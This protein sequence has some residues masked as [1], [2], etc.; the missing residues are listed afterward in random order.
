MLVGDARVVALDVHLYNELR[1]EMD[2]SV[3]ANR[4]SRNSTEEKSWHLHGKEQPSQDSGLNNLQL[5][6]GVVDLSQ[7]GWCFPLRVWLWRLCLAERSVVL[8]PFSQS[9]QLGAGY[10]QQKLQLFEAS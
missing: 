2:L 5:I 7:F 1:S 9:Q 3:F 6:L 10:A 4:A 8:L